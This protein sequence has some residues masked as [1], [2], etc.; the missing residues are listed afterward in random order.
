MLLVSR[1]QRQ[2]VGDP[3]FVERVVE[4]FRRY[5][6]EA[7][8][9]LPDDVLRKR[10]AHGIERG[11]SYGLTWE[12]SLTVFVAHMMRIN[13]EF[14]KHAAIQRV[15]HDASIEPDERINELP[16]MVSDE[17]WEEAGRQCD[18]ETYWQQIGAPTPG[19]RE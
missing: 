17:E 15:L 12:Y 14:D 19:A 2:Q 5:H 18:P 4:H 11:R 9:M 7:V 10:V 1:A 16:A 3:A 6:I 13:P 8:Y